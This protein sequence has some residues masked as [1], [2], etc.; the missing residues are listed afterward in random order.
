MNRCVKLE[1]IMIVAI[2]GQRY[3]LKSTEDRGTIKITR[4]IFHIE[5][6]KFNLIYVNHTLEKLR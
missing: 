1:Q 2:E 3:Y 4:E 6:P 5:P